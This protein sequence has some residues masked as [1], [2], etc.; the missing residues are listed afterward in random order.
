MEAFQVLYSQSLESL[1]FTSD[2]SYL[3]IVL[4]TLGLYKLGLNPIPILCLPITTFYLFID[5]TP[6]KV[7]LSEC[8]NGVV[9]GSEGCT[10]LAPSH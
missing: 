9:S 10:N 8:S 2:M 1:K 4:S 5:K 3:V 6:N 7:A